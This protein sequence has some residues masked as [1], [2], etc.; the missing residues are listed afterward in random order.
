MTGELSA[1]VTICASLRGN[2]TKED[3]IRW[4]SAKI[5][6]AYTRFLLVVR[7]AMDQIHEKKKAVL[8]ELDENNFNAAFNYFRPIIQR[9]INAGGRLLKEQVDKSV[10]FCTRVIRKVESSCFLSWTV[11]QLASLLNG[12][13]LLR[14]RGAVS[15]M[16]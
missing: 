5:A 6:K 12:A 9:T 4:H 10:E 14:T 7:S 3:A 15:V 16:R 2:Y 1:A 8:N 11:H 13:A